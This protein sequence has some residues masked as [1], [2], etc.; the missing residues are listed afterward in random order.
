MPA[1]PVLPGP[2]AS[3]HCFDQPSFQEPAM[4][5]RFNPKTLQQAV[6]VTVLVLA[7]LA[8]ASQARAAPEPAFQSA[9]AHFSQA[10]AGDAVAI[11]KAADAFALLLKAEPSNPVLMAYAG[12]SEAMKARNTALPWK[13]MSHAED[14]LALVDKSL[15]LLTPVHDAALQ[16]GTPGSLEVRL[17]AANTFLAMPGFMNRGAR[18]ARLLA[19]VLASPLFASAP[20][21]FQGTV[22]MLAASQATKDKRADDAQRFLNEVISRN[23]PQADKARAL[24]KAAA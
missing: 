22:W 2:Y 7:V 18:G 15:A 11:D 10:S 24:L 3:L 16:H 8:A 14:G 4:S 20:L 6:V 9:F 21:P 1:A 17:V 12:A 5:H 19:E 23:A 13:K